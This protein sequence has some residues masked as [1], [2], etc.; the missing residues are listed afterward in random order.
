MP[1][2]QVNR[3]RRQ[4]RGTA[5]NRRAAISTNPQ[6]NLTRRFVHQEQIALNNSLGSN[7]IHESYQ[8][9]N[10]LSVQG[11]PTIAQTFD[12]FRV[13]RARVYLQNVLPPIDTSIAPSAIFANV[14]RLP[15]N[16][17][18][19]V[20]A[21]T[22]VDHTTGTVAGVHI[23]A[24]NNI[25]FRVPDNDFS[26]KLVDFTPRVSTGDDLV[27]PT[28]N[29]ASCASTTLRWSGFQLYIVNSGA[30]LANS[31]WSNPL[32]QQKY[33]LRY[34]LDVEFKQ[35]IYTLTAPLLTPAI[36]GGV[37]EEP[38]EKSDVDPRIKTI[39]AIHQQK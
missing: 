21:M 20:S 14:A 37:V 9:I 10:M 34:E 29:F 5:Q 2:R 6:Q 18:P 25:Q 36:T 27:R 32:I 39:E 19:S 31:V 11:F 7:T 33:T 22:A 3:R 17:N 4:R 15:R 13:T 12:Q 23:Y 30:N 1:T 26:T 28:N 8:S 38:E 16:A 24:Y 35:P